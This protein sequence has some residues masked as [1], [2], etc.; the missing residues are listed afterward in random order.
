MKS[1]YI[2]S[3][4]AL[5]LSLGVFAQKDQLKALEKAFKNFEPNNLK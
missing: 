2:I 3:A 1:K 5:F 4:F